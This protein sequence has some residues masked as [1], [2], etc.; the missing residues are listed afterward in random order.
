MQRQS[1]PKRGHQHN[2]SHTAGSWRVVL[3]GV[4]GNDAAS[5]DIPSAHWVSVVFKGQRMIKAGRE[6][7]AVKEYDDISA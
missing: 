6:R 1:C 3:V 4:V 2:E 5:S 7:D